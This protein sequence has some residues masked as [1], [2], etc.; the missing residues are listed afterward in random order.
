MIKALLIMLALTMT[1]KVWRILNEQKIYFLY[2]QVLVSYHNVTVCK[3]KDL[4][5]KKDIKSSSNIQVISDEVINFILSSPTIQMVLAVYWVI[6]IFGVYLIS[7]HFINSARHS[8]PLVEQP[9]VEQNYNPLDQS[10]EANYK[11]I[12]FKTN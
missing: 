7:K 3:V 10:V 5:E 8:S 1:A 9:V 11:Q 2:F 4:S 12:R 6:L